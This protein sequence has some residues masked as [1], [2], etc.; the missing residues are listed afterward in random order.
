[1][2]RNNRS[3]HAIS[4]Q[5]ISLSQFWIQYLIIF[6][7]IL[8]I[9]LLFPRG[10]SLQYSYQLN[11][12]SRDPIIAPFTFSILSLMKYFSIVI[13]SVQENTLLIFE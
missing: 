13:P 2:I 11:D 1:M 4:D 12:I 9:S 3:E 8:V 6:G 5:L 10:Q 7:L